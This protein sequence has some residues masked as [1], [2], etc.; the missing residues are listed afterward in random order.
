M[1]V[2]GWG[3]AFELAL[4]AEAARWR[5]GPSRSRGG[6]RRPLERESSGCGPGPGRARRFRPPRAPLPLA[7]PLPSPQHSFLNPPESGQWALF[8]CV[9]VGGGG[10]WGMKNRNSF[11]SGRRLT[12]WF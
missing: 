4:G 12:L 9:C 7:S 2:G 3:E 1:C 8:V 11:T 10:R 5:S 6:E